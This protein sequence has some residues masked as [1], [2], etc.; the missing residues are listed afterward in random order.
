[1]R[2]P[3]ALLFLP[4]LAAVSCGGDGGDDSVALPTATAEPAGTATVGQV[5]A[6]T[7][8]PIPGYRTTE[9][10]ETVLG[11]AVVYTAENK[12]AGGAELFVRANYAP[13]DSFVCGSLDPGDYASAEAQ[14]Q[15]K[16]VL[17]AAHKSNPDLVWEFGPVELSGRAEGL[18][19]YTLSYLEEEAGGGV[20]RSSANSYRAWYHNGSVYVTLEVFA[21]AAAA[22]LSRGDVA[23]L[24]TKA[25]AEEAAREVFVVLEPELPR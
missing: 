17:P 8:L 1:M 11:V 18:Y 9:V 14:D 15:L 22:P 24:M 19:Y 7:E 6:L 13:C 2:W 5:L 10:R 20:S 12:T 21:R 3:A 4:L 16:S 23:R 25:E